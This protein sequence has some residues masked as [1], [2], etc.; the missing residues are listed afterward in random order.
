ML[1]P[2]V[3]PS[4]EPLIRVGVILP[5]DAQ[6]EITLEIPPKVNYHISSGSRK[7]ESIDSGEISFKIDNNFI[8]RTNIESF[9]NWKI[10]PATISGISPKSGIQVKNVV[11]GR[12]FH[13]QKFIDVFLAGSIE[14]SIIDNQLVLI[15]ELP[16]EAYLMCVATSEM[17]AECPDAL[18][19]AQTVTARSWMLANVEQ[20]HVEMSMDVCNDD[21][22]QR[23]QG[24][25]HLSL[26]SIAGA[27]K[28]Y[29]QVLLYKDKICDARYS[30][31]CG[32]IIETFATIWQGSDFPYL[33]NKFDSYKD[34]TGTQ[35]PL[36][37]DEKVRNWLEANPK[38]FCSPDIIPE[39]DLSQYLGN[40]DKEG[41]YFRWSVHY[42]QHE[43]LELLNNKLNLQAKAINKIK[44]LNRGGSGRII[45]LEIIYLCNND[46]IEKIRVNRDVEI[47]RVLH[48]H[49]LYSSCI[50]IIMTNLK[51]DI[52]QDITIRGAG[53]GH[54]VGLCQIGALGM[55]LKEYSTEEILY[56]YFPSS[57]LKKIY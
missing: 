30:K 32:G 15:N 44:P 35:L 31:S 39:S 2:N 55:S 49:F 37:T 28:T 24:T 43:L 18:I 52:P 25:K 12:G 16:I 50:D 27:K 5:E 36:N 46:K 13:W 45:E 38:A 14:I 29:G 40:V 20:K 19:E 1:E 4:R 10:S 21:C 7:S 47:R 23:Y 54:G 57:K 8:V 26:Q 51:N 33:N 9:A 22:C 34:I 41:T 53:W 3:M 6:K 56:H 11:A 42:S 17:S 48:D